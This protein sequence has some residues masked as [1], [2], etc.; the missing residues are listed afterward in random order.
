MRSD[1]AEELK[2]LHCSF[3]KQDINNAFLFFNRFHLN[4]LGLT[5]N[6]GIPGQT[7]VSWRNTL[8]ACTIMHPAH[9][10]IEPLVGPD[11]EAHYA[12][13]EQACEQLQAEGYGQ[14][15]AR[16]FCLLHHGSLFE[17]GQ[18]QGFEILGLGVA[19]RS[20]FDGYLTR[21]TNHLGLYI[22][23]AG[24][25]EKTTVEAI[26]LGESLSTRIYCTARLRSV[27]GLRLSAFEERF[28]AELPEIIREE[29]ARSIEQGLLEYQ[30]DCYI[31]TRRGLYQA[32][33]A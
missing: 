9:V 14:Y 17:L 33:E 6:Y 10:T 18:L 20:R 1:N 3:Q 27:E 13:Y 16:C 7:E 12:L 5:V 2:T 8:R 31:P 28:Q 29:L 26:P 25:Y 15:S 11:G 21:N 30:G 32:A 24:E 4:N 23:N 22:Q 19:A